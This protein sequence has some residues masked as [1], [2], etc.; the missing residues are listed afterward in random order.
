MSGREFLRY[1]GNTTSVE[2]VTDAGRAPADRSRHRRDRAR[3]AA[4]WAA[5]SARGRARCRSCSRTRTSITSRACRSSR[6][7]SSR[8]TR[9]GSSARPRRRACS[10]EATL[11]NQLAP[12]YS[13]L[14]GLENLAAGVSI[15]TI[16][17]GS[18]IA[19]PG[20]RGR[21]PRAVPHGS[22]WTTAFRI[23]AD[24]KT[25]TYLSDVEYPIVDDPLAGGARARARRRSPDPR[26]DA[27]RS[28]LRPAPRLGPLA[29]AR[30]RGRRRARGREE[31]RAV[32]SQSRCDRR[33][34]RRGRRAHRGAHRGPGVR[35]R[36]RELSDV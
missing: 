7:S 35:G 2:L 12:H 16:T 14:N 28:R 15:E 30:G 33:H 5:S 22:M 13:P 24:G 8:A 23:T 20:L 3:E 32:P 4:R 18:T 31:A 27:R 6:R 1:G 26:R 17:P 10:L 36:R 29:G 34:D 9:S 19:L 21:R 11:Q 25:V